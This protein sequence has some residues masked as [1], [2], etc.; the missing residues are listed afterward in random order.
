MYISRQL[1]V[2][3]TK[4]RDG[5]IAWY[6]GTMLV[7][8]CTFRLQD[9]PRSISVFW[10]PAL[11]CIH[12]IGNRGELEKLRIKKPTKELEGQEQMCL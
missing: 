7:Y 6:R 4:I 10:E 11:R 9:M 1:K 8:I 12:T 2:Q 3:D 5:D